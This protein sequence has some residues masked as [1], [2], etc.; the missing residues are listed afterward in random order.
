[1]A[2][3]EKP[4][5]VT[6]GVVASFANELRELRA[7]AG[8]PTYRDMARSALFSS[9]VLSSAASGTRLPTLQVTLGFVAACG[10]DREEW[11]RRWMRAASLTNSDAP[12]RGR[13]RNS[14]ADQAMPRP[15]QLPLRPSGFVGR[16]T[17]LDRLS[18]PAPTPVVITGPVGIG[19]SDFALHY[20]HRIA[21]DMV[22]GQLYAD[23][24]PLTGTAADAGYVLDGFLRALG[25]PADQ[26]PGMVDQ[27][28]GLY[29]SLL[30]ERRLLVLLDNVRDERQVRPLLAES[31]HSVTLVISR[32]PLLGLGGVRRIRL[33]VPPRADSIAMIT[34][35]VP[36]RAEAEPQ[37][38]DR[39]AELCGDL[40][41]ALDIALRK[42]VARP[43]LPL[44]TATAKL[45]ERDGALNWLRIGDLS[46]RESLRS[47]YQEVS[48]AAKTL[49]RR[50]ARLPFRCDPNS[51][52]HDEGELADELMDAG[53]LRR[54][55]R[56]GAY[57]V[58]RLVRAFAIEA[59]GSPDDHTAIPLRINVPLQTS[60]LGTPVAGTPSCAVCRN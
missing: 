9:S 13:Y 30:A 52:L 26:L 22:D 11:R 4:V 27:R 55:D 59:G 18:A 37:E 12:T 39:L 34:A 44:C 47:A 33:D 46:L 38:C 40:P 19:K 16:R 17:E 28:A 14:P 53:L 21:A 31:R 23:L 29:R 5:D 20:A 42:L 6:G 1:M 24:G 2:R 25:V 57:R 50:V 15:A 8:N 3:P 48:D 49:L 32:R 56:P 35:A 54:G 10:G 45:M 58:E 60:R 43:D 7:R 41:L 36:E 51:V